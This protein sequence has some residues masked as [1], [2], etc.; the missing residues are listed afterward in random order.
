ML[1]D[2]RVAERAGQSLDAQLCAVVDAGCPA[3]VFREKDLTRDERC[4]LAARVAEA[5]DAAGAQLII[6]SDASLAAELGAGLHLGAGD[7]FPDD[8]PRPLGRSCHDESELSGAEAEGVDYVTFSPVFETDT[9]PGYGPALGID[10]LA[11]ACEQHRGL[12]VYALGGISEHNAAACIDAGAAGVAVM[13]ALMSAADAGAVTR[14]L[15]RRTSCAGPE[16]L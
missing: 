5:A 7:A 1:T 14:E 9:K 3:I 13:G 2:R 4:R 16:D 11:A 10:A 6:A 8:P 12:G 15:L